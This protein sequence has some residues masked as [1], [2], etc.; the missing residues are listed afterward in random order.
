MASGKQ[1]SCSKECTR[2]SKLAGMTQFHHITE[3]TDCYKIIKDIIKYGKKSSDL[4]KYK[5]CTDCCKIRRKQ[6][7]KD[8]NIKRTEARKA[9]PNLIEV[10]TKGLTIYTTEDKLKAA[11]ERMTNKNP[12]K[13]SEVVKKVIDTRK[14]KIES[15][16]IKYKRGKDNHLWKGNR[17]NYSYIRS[18][19]TNWK[20]QLFK[21]SNWKCTM[22]SSNKKIEVH[23]VEKFT[24]IVSKFINKPI[25][26]YVQDSDEFQKLTETIIKYHNENNIG[27]VVCAECHSKI[28]SKRKLKRVKILSKSL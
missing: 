16:E 17:E 13:N 14:R 28:D 11:T 2:K 18:N 24:D 5:R 21:D 9:D 22:C 25:K 12:M 10:K 4:K 27:K 1:V 23:H 15:G 20:K 7:F 3:C 26:D 8:R 19:L 6:M